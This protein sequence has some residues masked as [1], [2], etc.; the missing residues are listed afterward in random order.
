MGI[1]ANAVSFLVKDTRK[2]SMQF[3]GLTSNFLDEKFAKKS[4][5]K[6]DK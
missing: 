1:I 5:E 2:I 4:K 6:N 3:N